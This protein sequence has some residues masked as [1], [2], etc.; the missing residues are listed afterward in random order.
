MGLRVY[1]RVGGATFKKKR[2]K[3][4]VMGLSPRGRGN[5][6]QGVKDNAPE[7]SIPAWAGQPLRRL[8]HRRGPSVYPRVGGATFRQSLG[9]SLKMGLSPRG[10]G[11]LISLFWRMARAGSIPAWAG[12][13]RLLQHPVHQVRVY[14]RVGGATSSPMVNRNS[15]SGLSPR[16]R[17]NLTAAVDGY[18][19]IRSIPAWAGQPHCH[20]GWLDKNTVYPRVGG[21]TT[22]PPARSG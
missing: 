15:E 10:R 18:V 3:L 12:Q 21:A 4:E 14:P 16:G 2:E 9:I 1:P 20:S 6:F 5:L 22:Q 17:G 7:R 11:N 13:P 8:A 19:L